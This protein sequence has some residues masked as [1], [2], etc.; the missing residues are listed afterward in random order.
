MLNNVKA[1]GL[2]RNRLIFFSVPDFDQFFL[3][4]V[5]FCASERVLY[6]EFRSH[7]KWTEWNFLS[8]SFRSF[9]NKQEKRNRFLPLNEY[10]KKPVWLSRIDTLHAARELIRV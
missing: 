4:L 5:S 2:Q 9:D 3:I 1:T 10:N 8:S 6:L 7:I